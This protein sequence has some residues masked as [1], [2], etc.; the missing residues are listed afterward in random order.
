MSKK[1]LL[2]VPTY[3]GD[4]RIE[5][6]PFLQEAA[7]HSIFYPIMHKPT[8]VA[9]NLACS[10]AKYLKCHL[11]MVDADA[12]PAPGTFASL[13]KQVEEN[14]CVAA[15]P[16]VAAGGQICV[17][18]TPP[19][20][21]DVEHLEGWHTADNFGTHCCAISLNVLE[22]IAPP[23]FSFDYSSEKTTY[24]GED[25]VFGRKVRAAGLDIWIDYSHWA[26]HI[27][28]KT[29]AKPRTL[30]ADDLKILLAGLNLKGNL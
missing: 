10:M 3:N 29:M 6:V 22:T 9:R 20:V 18:E 15:V 12:V 27:V 16:Y 4:I 23:W 7:A 28:R 13:A 17:G 2:A 26:D 21:E 25:T 11:V 8:D 19:K 30:T 14:S 24:L 1:Y 5:L